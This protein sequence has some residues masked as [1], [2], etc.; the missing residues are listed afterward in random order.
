MPLRC[1]YLLIFLVLFFQS[2]LANATITQV[3][4]SPSSLSAD[5]STGLN[6]SIRWVVT[7]SQEDARSTQGSYYHPRIDADLALANMPLTVTAPGGST[8]QAIGVPETLNLS[9]S[10]V[11]FWISLGLNQVFFER[12]FSSRDGSSLIGR[13]TINLNNSAAPP[14]NPAPPTAAPPRANSQGLNQFRTPS[15]ELVIKRLALHFTDRST[16]KFVDS[17]AELKAQLEV[18]YTGNGILRGYWQIADPVSASEEL[19]FRT[20]ALVNH[21]LTATQSSVILSPPLPTQLTGRYYLRFCVASI[22]R[23]P[24]PDADSTVCSTELFST[25]VGYQVFPD[26]NNTARLDNLFPNRENATAQTLFRWPDVPGA[27]VHQLQIFKVDQ[28]QASTTAKKPSSQKFIAGM[29]LP[30]QTTKTP[31]SAYVIG[32]LIHQQNYAWRISSFGQNGELLA[33]SELTGFHF[34]GAN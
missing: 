16:V 2:L 23:N 31:L 19:Y 4:A 22:G 34:V 25:V 9:A 20:L 32:Q 8:P 27:V 6:A 11:A 17:G 18:T 26:R 29:L 3:T 5:S 14:T 24:A 33:Q 15:S 28:F 1:S 12:R 30:G 10:Q 7:L 13:V 21:S